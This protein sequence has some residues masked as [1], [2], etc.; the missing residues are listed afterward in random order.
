MHARHRRQTCGLGL[1]ADPTSAGLPR[2]AALFDRARRRASDAPEQPDDTPQHLDLL[3]ANWLH[4]LVLR[5]ETNVVGFA[6]E[7]LDGR[8]LPGPGDDDVAFLS[9]GLWTHHD[10]I[11]FDDA[12]VL[13]RVPA[14]LQQ[15]L[16]IGAASDL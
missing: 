4:R 10:E 8:L 5:L 16:P 13:H 11:P 2:K 6:I 1:A 3:A 14:Y 12:R 15:V 7:A 9:R